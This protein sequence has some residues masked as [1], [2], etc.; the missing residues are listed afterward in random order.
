MVFFK[1][2]LKYICGNINERWFMIYFKLILVLREEIL[3]L[4]VEVNESSVLLSCMNGFSK[5]I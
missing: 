5:I 4:V 2:G 1:I 3:I